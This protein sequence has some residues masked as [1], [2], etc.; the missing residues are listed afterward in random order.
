M[1]QMSLAISAVLELAV[2]AASSAGLDG[3]LGARISALRR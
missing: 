1:I 2:Y 3:A